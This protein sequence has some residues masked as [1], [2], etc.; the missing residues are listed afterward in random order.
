MSSCDAAK[1]GLLGRAFY[2]RAVSLLSLRDPD[3]AA[4][5]CRAALAFEGLHGP[6]AKAV[7]AKLAQ[8]L[9]FSG[10]LDGSLAAFNRAVELD[11]SDAALLR[12]RAGVLTAMGRSSAALADLDASLALQLPAAPAEPK[13]PRRSPSVDSLRV[14]EDASGASQVEARAGMDPHRRPAPAKREAAAAL[15]TRARLHYARG[16]FNAAADDFEAA[17][18]TR[19]LDAPSTARV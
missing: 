3:G 1:A 12:A 17:L 11:S 9:V 5:D 4:R 2:L 14:D 7:H 16:E 19:A 10:D 13:T 18:A 6:S 8:S 15:E